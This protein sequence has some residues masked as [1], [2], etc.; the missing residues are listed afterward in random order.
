[1]RT[2]SIYKVSLAGNA[3]REVGTGVLEAEREHE[4]DIH[5]HV[6]VRIF[7]IH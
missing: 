4:C 6:R 2:E 1:M 5:V 3:R 7:A